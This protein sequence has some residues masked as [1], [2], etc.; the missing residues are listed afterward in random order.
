MRGGDAKPAP[1]V[2]A[3]KEAASSSYVAVLGLL[4]C[5]PLGEQ[6]TELASSRSLPC[7]PQLTL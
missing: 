7:M 3:I 6:P 5:L 2:D 1:K 4:L